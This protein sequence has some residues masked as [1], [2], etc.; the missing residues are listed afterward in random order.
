MR[1]IILTFSLVALGA[2]T[3]K[4]TGPEAQVA[5]TEHKGEVISSGVLVF[6]NGIEVDTSYVRKL[7]TGLIESVEVLKGKS[8]R[9]RFGDRALN[10]V[11]LVSLKRA[12]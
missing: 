11:V 4:L 8:A 12:K 10:G 9:E 2:C 6:V 3:E 7:D 5:A 1:K